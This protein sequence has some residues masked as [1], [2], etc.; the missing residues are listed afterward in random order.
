VAQAFEWTYSVEI[1]KKGF[2]NRD[3]VLLLSRTRPEITASAF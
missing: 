2:L 1:V 3:V